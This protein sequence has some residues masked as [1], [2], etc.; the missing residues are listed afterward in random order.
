MYVRMRVDRILGGHALGLQMN[1]PRVTAELHKEHD[2]VAA[3]HNHGKPGMC[4][5]SG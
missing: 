4:T 3:L 2:V 5:V 1:P